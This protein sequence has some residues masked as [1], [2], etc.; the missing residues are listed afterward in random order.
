MITDV[1][2]FQY[3][4]TVV[5]I[6]D[7]DTMHLLVMLC[8]VDLGFSVRARQDVRVDVRLAAI[9]A[10]E[11]SSPTGAADRD[12][13]VSLAPIGTTVELW[14]VKDRTEKYGR[15]LAWIR[16]DDGR[17]VNDEMVK[18]GHAVP[19]LPTRAGRPSALGPTPPM[20]R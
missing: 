8:D 2:P 19:Y 20:A 12:F 9:N 3:R 7:G 15:Y 11:L 10:S 6:H 5:D 18:N 4:A 17:I 13:L 14:T 1:A 16:L